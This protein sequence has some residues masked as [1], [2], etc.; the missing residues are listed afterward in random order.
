MNQLVYLLS[1]VISPESAGAAG[2]AATGAAQ[3]GLFATIMSKPGLV[4]VIYCVVIFGIIW[5]MSKPEKKKQQQ[6]EKEREGI[7]PGDPVVLKSGIYG[8]VTDVTAE[9]FI[10]EFGT[11]KGVRIP[12]MKE[13]VA[14]VREP[15]LTDT[16]TVAP[17]KEK[18]GLF[19][20]GKKKETSED[21]SSDN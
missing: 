19:G 11:N 16:P 1:T 12:I 5:I 14:A 18:K 9:C 13:A 8:T 6:Q 4:I 7:K 2:D 15:N 17:K 3:P 20:F 21:N 10:V